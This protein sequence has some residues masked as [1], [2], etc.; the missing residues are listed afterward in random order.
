[1]TLHQQR[2]DALAG[3]GSAQQ[4]VESVLAAEA[5]PSGIYPTRVNVLILPKPVEEKIGSILLPEAKKEADKFA[6]Q[7][8]TI[9]A[10]SPLAFS[11]ATAEEWGDAMPK[12]GDRVIFAKY[13]GL[14][15]KCK[16]GVDYVVM[17][18]EDIIAVVD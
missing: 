7:E 13:A 12:I 3:M 16:D 17:K 6:T 5:N 2:L 10:V 18:D 8:G 15:R 4:Y 9:L 14:R 1:M 11:F